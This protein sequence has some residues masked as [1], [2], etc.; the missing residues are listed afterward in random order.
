MTRLLLDHPWPVEAVNDSSSRGFKVLVKFWNLVQEQR[1]GAVKFI[2]IDVYNA[3]KSRVKNRLRADATAFRIAYHFVQDLANGPMAV[4]DPEPSPPLGLHWKRALR[5][6]LENPADWKTPQI[7]VAHVRR[8]AWQEQSPEV[9]IRCDDR[10]GAAPERR[11][12]ATLEEY[13]LHRFAVPDLDPW[14]ALK[15][16]NAPSPGTRNNHPCVLPR[17]PCLAAVHLAELPSKLAEA[18]G[19]GWEIDGRFYFVP[20]VGY[21]PQSVDKRPWREGRAFEH[22]TTPERR[23]GKRRKGPLDHF[24]RI[25]AWDVDER[26]WDVQFPDGDYMRISHDGR[27]LQGVED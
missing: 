24:G 21:G 9:S 26:H 25:W 17:P 20:P 13:G 5:Q 18:A 22:A 11:V 10:P 19:A 1:A 6:E 2:D 27:W 15:V 4:P 16:I 8:P 3:A 12:L 23:A 7:V 14:Q